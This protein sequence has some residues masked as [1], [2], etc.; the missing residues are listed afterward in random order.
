MSEQPT[1]RPRPTYGLPGE[2][3]TP[4][5]A[6]SQSPFGASEQPV[7]QG[8][9]AE[10]GPSYNAGTTP[11]APAAPSPFSTAAPGSATAPGGP[12][13]S[14]QQP[15]SGLPRGEKPRRRGLKMTII[16]GVL[17]VL[18]IIAVIVS[19]V[20][21]VGSMASLVVG[22]PHPIENGKTTVKAEAFSMLMVATPAADAPQAT[23]TAT[24]TNPSDVQ[25]IPQETDQPVPLGDSKTQYVYKF[26]VVTENDTTVTLSCEG[27]NA[28]VYTGPAPIGSSMIGGVA[29]I[30]LSGLV[31]LVGFILLIV[32][33]VR[34]VRSGRVRKE[35]DRTATMR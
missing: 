31:G 4:H 8:S 17:T 5:Q 2:P 32:G 28:A 24:G 15:P 10:P 33:I 3:A 16:G 34:L 21:M 22:N 9:Q 26:N 30:I 6:Q 29:A 11:A 1:N 14:A 23:C 19:V 20:V 7:N 25:I 27:T 12:F 18:A 35:W 13:Y